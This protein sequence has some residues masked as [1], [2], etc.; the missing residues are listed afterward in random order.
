MN[1]GARKELAVIGGLAGLA[2]FLCGRKS[3]ARAVGAISALAGAW[4]QGDYSFRG[5]VAVITGGSRG[6]GFALAR[7][8]LRA[9][10]SVVLLAR[11]QAEL[12]RAEERLSSLARGEIFIVPCDITDDAELK[13]AVAQIVKK[14][15]TIDLWIND[16]G[17]ILV[18]PLPSMTQAD[19]D[20]L[21]KTQVQAVWS[22]TRELL[23]VFR[24]AGGGKI[25]NISS[26]GG[27]IAVPHLGPYST[28]KFALAGLSASLNAELA[29]ENIQV[30][31]VFPGLMRVGSAIQAVVKG[32]HQKEFVWFALGSVTPGISVSANDAAGR[33][34]R[35]VAR[36]DAQLIFPVVMKAAT[37][38]QA[39][40][41]ELS[42][43]TTRVVSGLLP[44]GSS[45]T[46]KTGAQ[47]QGL[48]S[49]LPGSGFVLS[50]L[51]EQQQENNE[52]R[53][54]D[55]RFNLGLDDI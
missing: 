6:L 12:E 27:K 54:D 33:I 11:D 31:T 34:L 21:W 44:K 23:P 45:V 35:A 53:A 38:A 36:G 26:I 15:G 22:A 3:A 50:R 8:L 18:G 48:L 30:T 16:A 2:L 4:P 28:A 32:D 14:F 25:V 51:D 10:A 42:A 9:G 13:S 46:G 49:R 41:P 29:A 17:A 7:N 24:R 37:L 19:F 47:S 39:V 43:W 1:S 20:A 40:F 5:K 55:A 52:T